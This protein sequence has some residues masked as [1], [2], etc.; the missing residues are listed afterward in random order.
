MTH[1][2]ILIA[3]VIC[4]VL[5]PGACRAQEMAESDFQGWADIRTF[6]N[7]TNAFVYDGTL[8]I[9]HQFTGE[10]W[11]SAYIRPSVRYRVSH[12]LTLRG[13]VG[14][15]WLDYEVNVTEIRP[16]QGVQAFWPTFGGVTF[17]HYVRLEQRFLTPDGGDTEFFHRFRYRIR[18]KTDNR[19]VLGMST[20]SFALIAWEF[21]S[22]LNKTDSELFVRADR[23]YVG[24]GNRVSEKWTVQ[25]HYIWR[26]SR[27]G[28]DESLELYDHV[29]RLRLAWVIH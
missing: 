14:F 6:Y 20:P 13:G 27:I 11:N 9:R 24:V 15:A 4:A 16:Y 12:L 22:N 25:V 1:R 28:A 10:T 8:G 23:F 17:D 18:A 5:W 19:R 7:F 3:T 21:F 29:V 26:R 2:L